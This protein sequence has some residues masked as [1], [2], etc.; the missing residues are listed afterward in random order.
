MFVLS[1]SFIAY[2]PDYIKKINEFS[3]D[4]STASLDAGD[5]HP[6]PWHQ[7]GVEPVGLFRRCALHRRL[8]L[9]VLFY[10]FITRHNDVSE[11]NRFVIISSLVLTNTLSHHK[12]K[13]WC[14]LSLEYHYFV[15][16]WQFIALLS[17]FSF[18]NDEDTPGYQKSAIA[19]YCHLKRLSLWSGINLLTKCL[20]R[21]LIG[22][23]KHFAKIAGLR[24]T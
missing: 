1:A 6:L 18:Y 10:R 19:K 14:S 7:T 11:G 17:F 24:K 21:Y 13:N 12:N 5:L 3:S 4:I 9:Y 16:L 23:A 20:R 22:L 15:A 8:M 2:A